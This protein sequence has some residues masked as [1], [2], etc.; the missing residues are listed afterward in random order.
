[1]GQAMLPASSYLKWEV[2]LPRKQKSEAILKTLNFSFKCNS[3]KSR[4]CW[5]TAPWSGEDDSCWGLWGFGLKMETLKCWNGKFLITIKL[6]AD[7]C[8]STVNYFCKHFQ[9]WGER[10]RDEWLVMSDI[11][12][13]QSAR[14][15]H[16]L[17]HSY[18]ELTVAAV[19]R[20]GHWTTAFQSSG[21]S[22]ELVQRARLS[23]GSQER[24]QTGMNHSNI[25]ALQD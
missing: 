5:V 18:C 10:F 22:Q 25:L 17:S 24:Y 19:K 14:P 9:H 21:K 16:F 12:R 23:H 3:N 6:L 8:L 7:F 1:M 20:P 11:H 13:L 2:K 15:E 4:V